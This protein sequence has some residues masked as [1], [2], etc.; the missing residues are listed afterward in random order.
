[1]VL[2]NEIL[3]CCCTVKEDIRIDCRQRQAEPDLFDR[4]LFA[5]NSN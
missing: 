2:P 3:T 1:M 4:D 5:E